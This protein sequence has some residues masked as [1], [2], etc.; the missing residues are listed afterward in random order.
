MSPKK[1]RG[2]K[3]TLK[4][5]SRENKNRSTSAAKRQYV[6][7]RIRMANSVVGKEFPMNDVRTN[8]IYYLILS[9]I[10]LKWINELY[11]T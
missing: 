2:K 7:P 11:Y 9:L 6:Q 10:E 4:T 5:Y 1:L 3:S 8:I